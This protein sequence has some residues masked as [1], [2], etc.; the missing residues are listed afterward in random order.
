MA[1]TLRVIRHNKAAINPPIIAR[2][3]AGDG[4]IGRSPENDLCLPDPDR[5]VSSRHAKLTFRD[6]AYYVVDV[7][8]N[9]T[10]LNAADNRLVRD[11]AVRLANGDMLGICGY[12][13]QVSIDNHA[14]PEKSPARA[15]GVADPA[16]L[17]GPTM[18]ERRPEAST[19]PPAQIPRPANR[20]PPTPAEPRDAVRTSPPSVPVPAG[21]HTQLINRAELLPQ[22]PAVALATAPGADPT[23]E[24][25][26][27]DAFVEGL[28]CRI[29]ATDQAEQQR[30][31]QNAGQL[32]RTFSQ[33][34]VEV[35]KVRS[36][37]KNE[38]RLEMT[39]IQHSENNPF[40]FSL[41]LEET[42][43][44]I[45]R[46][47]EGN[48]R[49]LPPVE[50]AASAC[51]DLKDHQQAIIHGLRTLLRAVLQELDPDAIEQETPKSGVIEERLNPAARKARAW[52]HYV[53]TFKQLHEEVREDALRRFDRGFA[54][55]YE[56]YTRRCRTER[57]I[58]GKRRGRN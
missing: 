16:S 25:R 32:L 46:E 52:D 26:L 58:V 35:L 17:G 4:S 55:G 24:Q 38:L 49:M 44:R 54:D 50:A 19:M 22:R 53:A 3:G 20:Q 11:S 47:P 29:Q 57:G 34:L 42:L 27:F 45:L 7:S 37:F 12:E 31:F 36:H 9:G 39:T 2:F 43:E 56:S 10:L 41:D 33:G 1:L 51:A 13:I 28:G 30:I 48:S 21:T 15:P 14:L 40:K 23:S 8:T 5:W 18:I 6:G